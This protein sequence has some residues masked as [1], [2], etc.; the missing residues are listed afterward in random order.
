[1]FISKP[2]PTFKCKLFVARLTH[3]FHLQ[4]VL[5]FSFSTI[6]MIHF[7]FFKLHFSL[8]IHNWFSLALF[9]NFFIYYPIMLALDYNESNKTIKSIYTLA[10]LLSIL[11]FLLMMNET[12]PY[13]SYICCYQKHI[14]FACLPFSKLC[15]L[16]IHIISYPSVNLLKI[17]H[18]FFCFV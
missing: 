2:L 16:C 8:V 17:E 14:T 9:I 10:F 12:K 7:L 18:Q 13:F 5:Y 3:V 6:S 4:K 11:Y 1:M 15:T